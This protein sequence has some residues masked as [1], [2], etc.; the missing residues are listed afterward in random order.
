MSGELLRRLRSATINFTLEGQVSST[1]ADSTGRTGI[2][3][4]VAVLADT[5]NY[6]FNPFL[7]TLVFEEGATLLDMDDMDIIGDTAGALAMRTASL[8]LAVNPGD[9]FYVWQKLNISAVRGTRF[10][11]AFN[12]LTSSF[13]QPENVQSLSIPE[14]A[15]LGVAM[16]AVAAVAVSTR[17]RI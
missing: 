12:T 13:S 4:T 10:A 6:G 3:A 16:A 8:S 11:D 7:S 15:T 2:Y 5:P 14:P 1:P 9:T 17:R